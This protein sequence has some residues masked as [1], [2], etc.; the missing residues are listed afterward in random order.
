MT[1]LRR[2]IISTLGP[3][4][5]LALVWP[6]AVFASGLNLYWDDCSAAGATDKTSACNTNT[7]A[8]ALIGSFVAPGGVA[9]LTAIE[10]TLDIWTS[11]DSL[12][13]WWR[14]AA[15]D[16][17]AGKLSTNFDFSSGPYTCTDPWSGA[18]LGGNA[19]VVDSLDAQHA[20]L[21]IVAAVTPDRQLALEADQ[22][23]YAFKVIISFQK[24]AGTGSCA[25]CD[26][27]VSIALSSLTLCQVDGVDNVLLVDPATSNV[28]T[29]QGGAGES[30]VGQVSYYGQIRSVLH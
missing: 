7:G 8:A 23:Y 11:S 25:G 13:N 30:Y 2:R 1:Q 29:W 16:C 28:A 14:F 12:P 21:R 27:P 10:A 26:E 20:Q 18:A 22:E 4:A 3:L 15:G 19:Y 9:A 17:R 24:T 5:L 6:G